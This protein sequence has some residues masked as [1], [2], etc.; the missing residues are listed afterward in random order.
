MKQSPV[1][2]WNSLSCRT[3]RALLL[4]LHFRARHRQCEQER[5]LCPASS[6]RRAATSWG[7]GH[8]SARNPS[9]QWPR[10]FLDHYSW[11]E[12]REGLRLLLPH[13]VYIIHRAS[14]VLRAFVFCTLFS[15]Q[16]TNALHNTNPTNQSHA[17]L[18]S[19]AAQLF[20]QPSP[21]PLL[22]LG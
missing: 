1:L 21:S 16:C 3:R 8:S 2:T 12:A 4:F 10:V 17:E 13:P 7:Q 9:L 18:Y 6:S 20:L 15:C 5:R 14:S 19:V 22:G 11:E